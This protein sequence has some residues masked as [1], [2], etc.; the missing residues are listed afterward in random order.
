MISG[1]GRPNRP[2]A[3]LG[4][5][6]PHPVRGFTL[7]ELVVVLALIGILAGFVSLAVGDGG[8][9]ARVRDTAQLLRRLSE[10]AA[11]EAV[12]S[13]RPL[14]IVLG[15]NRVW[16]REWRDGAWQDRPVDRFYRPHVLPPD[17]RIRVLGRDKDGLL[18][19]QVPAV[20][21]PDGSAEML[22]LEFSGAASRAGTQATVLTLVPDTNGYRLGTP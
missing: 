19:A 3:I 17:V 10:A 11:D 21:L 5:T 20:L 8:R 1:T 18:G 2:R 4:V 9:A 16:L 12:M 14:A 6:R 15:E 7:L 13:N 22:A